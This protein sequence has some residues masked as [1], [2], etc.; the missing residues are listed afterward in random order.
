MTKRLHFKNKKLIGIDSGETA[1]ATDGQATIEIKASIIGA[2]EIVEIT[3]DEE[4]IKKNFD[5]VTLSSKK[6]ILIDGKKINK[7]PK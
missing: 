5:K 6:E 2:D 3:T 1:I 7:S 4:E